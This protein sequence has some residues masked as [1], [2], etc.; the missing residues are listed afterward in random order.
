MIYTNTQTSTYKNDLLFSFN[1]MFNHMALEP[2]CGA[3]QHGGAQT[4][5]RSFKPH[6][7]EQFFLDSST[8]KGRTG[9]SYTSVV[10]GL[11]MSQLLL[12]P[13]ENCI[14]RKCR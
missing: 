8:N 6:L 5:Y 3:L 12:C 14:V 2:R 1:H 13:T 9:K 10:H 4:G 7:H 11:H